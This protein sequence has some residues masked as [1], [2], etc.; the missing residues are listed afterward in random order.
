M[1]RSLPLLAVRSNRGHV[2]PPADTFSTDFLRPSES[3]PAPV[4]DAEIINA[5]LEILA[6]RIATGSVIQNMEDAKKY[7]AV[8]FA[9]LEHEVFA[10]VYLTNR[11]QVIA[12]EELFRGTVDGASVHPREVVKS[13]LQYNAAALLIAH[14]HP[15]GIAEPSAADEL[16]T[17]RLKSALALVDIRIIDH[18]VIAGDCAVSMA[19]RGLL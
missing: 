16:I 9:G 19:E 17:R 2:R 5:A 12:C 18:L 11:H 8:R 15:S 3:G 7:L 13:A 1:S 6:S 4:R 14:P 10:I